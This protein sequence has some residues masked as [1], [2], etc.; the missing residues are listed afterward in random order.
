MDV[1][2]VAEV[3]MLLRD[4]DGRH[5]FTPR[6]IR[7]YAR[8]GVL[9]PSGRVAGDRGARL[10]T[11]EDVA[12]LRLLWMLQRKW[13]LSERVV[14]AL[15]VYRHAEFRAQLASRAGVIEILESAAVSRGAEDARTIQWPVR[16]PVSFVF[17]RLQTKASALRRRRPKVWTGLGWTSP[18]EAAAM[19]SA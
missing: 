17:E 15:F 4:V 16:V 6:A 18:I 13:H 3:A 7:Y 19:V 12:M 10:Y 1:F 9:E 11:L 2:T 8:A 14:W 5:A